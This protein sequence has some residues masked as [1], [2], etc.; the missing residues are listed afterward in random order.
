MSHFEVE[1]ALYSL[2]YSIIILYIYWCISQER[3]IKYFL[4][5]N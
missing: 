5:Q 2:K 4:Y 1:F 3:N